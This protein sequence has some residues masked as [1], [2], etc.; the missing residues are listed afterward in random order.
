MGSYAIKVISVDKVTHDVLH[1]VTE[2]PKGYE[3]T[4]GQ[5]TNVAIKKS[6]WEEESRPFTFTSR[7]DDAQLEFVIKMY[8]DHEGVT[9][10]LRNLKPD[11]QLLIDEPGGPLNI[12]VQDCLLQVVPVLRPLFRFSE[13]C[14]RPVSSPATACC[15]ATSGNAILLWRRNCASG[16]AMIL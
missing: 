12:R 4:P 9:H 2:K 14:M 10:E 1:I 11:D 15:S 8:P 13:R 6:G 16:W 7:P 5:A 3:F